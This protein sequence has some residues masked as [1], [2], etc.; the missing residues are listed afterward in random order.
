M[1]KV[2]CILFTSIFPVYQT[3][4]ANEETIR[5]WVLFLIIQFPINERLY[6]LQIRCQSRRPNQILIFPPFGKK[7]PKSRYIILKGHPIIYMLKQKG[8]CYYNHKCL[9]SI[10][11]IF[12]YIT[13]HIFSNK[14]L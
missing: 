9:M 3:I 5:S 13:M 7:L 14:A 8:I 4:V 11:L 10:S 6:E 1:F 12:D 2:R